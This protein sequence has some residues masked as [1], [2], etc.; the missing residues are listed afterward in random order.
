MQLTRWVL[1]GE[2]TWREVEAAE[3]EEAAEPGCMGAPVII[4]SAPGKRLSGDDTPATASAAACA[5]AAWA[6]RASDRASAAA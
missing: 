1:T 4:T 6:A 2:C 5:S 3:A